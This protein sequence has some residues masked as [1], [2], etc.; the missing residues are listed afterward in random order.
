MKSISKKRISFNWRN[1]FFCL[2]LFFSLSWFTLHISNKFIPVCLIDWC[3]C[4][5]NRVQ[6]T[7]RRKNPYCSSSFS[8]WFIL[9]FIFSVFLAL[10]FLHRKSETNKKKHC[11]FVCS[12]IDYKH[13][14]H[15]LLY[16]TFFK[17]K[18]KQNWPTKPDFSNDEE[19]FFFPISIYFL[20]FIIIIIIKH[21][22]FS[23]S[24]VNQIDFFN[25]NQPVFHDSNLFFFINI[26]NN[27]NDGQLNCKFS[28]SHFTNNFVQIS[29]FYSFT[30]FDS[31]HAH[32]VYNIE[33]NQFHLWIMN[34]ICYITY[35][36]FPITDQS[37]ESDLLTIQH[38]WIN[39]TE[40]LIF[41]LKSLFN[42]NLNDQDHHQQFDINLNFLRIIL[43]FHHETSLLGLFTIF[44][45]YKIILFSIKNLKCNES[46]VDE[47]Y[48]IADEYKYD[49]NN[50]NSFNM[51]EFRKFKDS[52]QTTKYYKIKK[53]SL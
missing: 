43:C 12:N 41:N 30:R 29:F 31:T 40:P 42:I 7:N 23:S 44:I 22:H 2:I 24:S 4:I 17:Q 35:N 38:Q 1:I 45:L 9:L 16:V 8:E 13:T 26:L 47:D 49:S 15:L 25:L 28:F 3:F 18:T 39:I 6:Q 50:K 46:I 27:N 34:D 36:P 19:V 32:I 10:L 48:S 37:N 5:A 33:C 21:L 51:D 53:V 14:L 20:A 52:Y 11:L